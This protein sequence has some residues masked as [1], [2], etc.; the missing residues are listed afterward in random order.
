ML[1]GGSEGKRTKR[2]SEVDREEEVRVGV[3]K[4]IKGR[5]GKGRIKG[6]KRR[7]GLGVTHC[8]G[9]GCQGT[10]MT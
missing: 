1:S 3:K 7:D 4:G 9:S 2:W 8:G 10:R 6:R 5:G